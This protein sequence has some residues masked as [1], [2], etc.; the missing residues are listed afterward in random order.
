MLVIMIRR[1]INKILRIIKPPR[2]ITNLE[3]YI[4]TG[5]ITHGD[6][7]KFEGFSV[8]SVGFRKGKVNVKIGN[9]CYLCCSIMLQSDEAEI[10]I[11][12]GVFIGPGTTLFCREKMVFGNDIMVSWDCTFIDTNAHSLHSYE[13][14]N[15]VL[16]SIK[17][18]EYKDWTFV[19]NT[20]VYIEDKCWI[21]FKSIILKGVKLGQGTVVGAGSVVSKSTQAYGVYG[22]NPALLVKE[23]D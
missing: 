21:G 18:H 3:R 12:D 15:D 2:Q 9:N 11:G 8:A 13:R 14:T 16:D 10:V 6:N 22:G 19:K 1:I 23:T 4:L 7:C 20:P 17:G 5:N